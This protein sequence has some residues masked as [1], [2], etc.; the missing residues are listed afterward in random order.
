MPKLKTRKAAAK[1]FKAS[2]TGKFI[3]RRA[4]RN[5][6]LDHKSSKLKRHLGT[7]AVVDERDE[8]RVRLMI[9]YA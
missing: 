7:K 9:P 8:E 4:F 1:R 3:R 5:H 6:L 2:G